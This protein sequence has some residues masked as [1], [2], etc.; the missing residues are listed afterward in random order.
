M[1]SVFSEITVHKLNDLH[2]VNQVH[3]TQVASQKLPLH[4]GVNPSRKTR[5]LPHKT[6]QKDISLESDADPVFSL[7]D[8]VDDTEPFFESEE[9]DFSSS[10]ECS[11]LT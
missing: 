10:G 5:R 8:F 3:I 6:Q 2:P 1:L 4:L 9:D 11:E 7:D